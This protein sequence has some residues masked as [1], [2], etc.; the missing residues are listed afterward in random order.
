MVFLTIFSSHLIEIL[1]KADYIL[2]LLKTE[3]GFPHINFFKLYHE[4]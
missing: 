3:K 4:M 1:E 2:I